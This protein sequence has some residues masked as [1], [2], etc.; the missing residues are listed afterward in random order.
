MA[1]LSRALEFFAPDIARQ[2]FPALDRQP[3]D[4]VSPQS[5]PWS[6]NV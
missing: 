5:P 1:Q 6:R 2:E 3:Y 4:R